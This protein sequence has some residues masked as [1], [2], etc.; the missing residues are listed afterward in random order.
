VAVWENDGQGTLTEHV[1]D[2]EK[3]SHLGAQAVDIDGDGDLDIVSIAWDDYTKIHLWRNDAVTSAPTP[4]STPIIRIR[5]VSS[6]ENG[7]MPELR[8][9]KIFTDTKSRRIVVTYASPELRVYIDDMQDG[10]IIPLA[11][12]ITMLRTMFYFLPAQPWSIPL[13]ELNIRIYEAIYFAILL[14]PSGIVLILGTFTTK[15]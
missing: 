11:P 6:G 3:E 14:L 15:A 4:T 9:P 7:M 1:V 8:V 10:R 2:R 12:G 13:R 5:T